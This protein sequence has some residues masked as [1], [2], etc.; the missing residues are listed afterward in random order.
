VVR[1]TGMLPNDEDW[2]ASDQV[3]GRHNQQILGY[4]LS[5]DDAAEMHCPTRRRVHVTFAV[6][7]SFDLYLN[8][9]S[10]K[11]RASRRSASSSHSSMMPW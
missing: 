2:V 9:R 7:G 3:V 5:D 11:S 4:G 8:T 6:Y 1:D 10:T